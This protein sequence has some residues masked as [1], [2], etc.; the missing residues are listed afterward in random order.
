MKASLP[1]IAFSSVRV[2]FDKTRLLDEAL[3]EE[4]EYFVLFVA[5]VY[6]LPMLGHFKLIC[7]ALAM[8]ELKEN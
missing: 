8:A 2:A 3:L 5:K 6:Q 4:G 7:F 1:I